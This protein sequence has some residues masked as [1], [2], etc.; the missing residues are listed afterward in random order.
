MPTLLTHEEIERQRLIDYSTLGQFLGI[1]D[2]VDDPKWRL[3]PEKAI[4]RL[5][6]IRDEYKKAKA[7]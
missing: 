4:S 5:V 2:M 7:E 3:T 1:A 6:E